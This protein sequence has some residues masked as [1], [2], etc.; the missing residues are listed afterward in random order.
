M[1]S[2]GTPTYGRRKSRTT[3]T[4]IHSAAM[5]GYGKTCQGRW[6]IGKSGEK[7]S[8]IPVLVARQK[9]EMM[10]LKE[11]AVGWL[12]L[13]HLNW[14]RL[15]NAKSCLYI[16]IYIATTQEC[17]EQY[18]TS[19]GGSTPQSSSSTATYHPSRKLSKLDEPDMWDTTEEVGTNS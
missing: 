7:G 12:G 18:W 2:Y 3:S 15:F 1:Y 19:P 8:R 5:W 16:Y 11:I 17:C 10:M 6:T 14:C 9:D 4:N 13:W